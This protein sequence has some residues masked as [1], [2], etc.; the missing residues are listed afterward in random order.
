M[1]PRGSGGCRRVEQTLVYRG[2]EHRCAAPH[3]WISQATDAVAEHVFREQCLVED[4][5]KIQAVGLL[6]QSVVAG[7][8]I[9]RRLEYLQHVKELPDRHPRQYSLE[10]LGRCQ[11]VARNI[12]RRRIVRGRPGSAAVTTGTSGK[13]G[14]PTSW[15]TW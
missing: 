11:W 3:C 2:F 10:L 14:S 13:L 9:K 7:P 5:P 4:W 12:S 1:R 8:C 15:T 6:C